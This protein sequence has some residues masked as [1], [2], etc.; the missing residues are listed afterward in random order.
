VFNLVEQDGSIG[1]IT[2]ET[3]SAT[4]ELSGR[5]STV[6]S[7]K[8]SSLGG[9]DQSEH[10]ILNKRVF[11]NQCSDIQKDQLNSAVGAAKGYV[12]KTVRYLKANPTGNPLQKTWYGIWDSSRYKKTLGGFETL[13]DA[14][15]RWTYDCSCTKGGGVAAYVY[16]TR[17]GYVYICPLFWTL[18]GVG[19][20]SRAQTIIHEGTHFIQVLNTEDHAYGQEA[21]KALAKKNPAN[22]VI[23]A[24]NNAFFALSTD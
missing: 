15:A 24:D 2:A 23:N 8:S 10:R 11:F 16:K 17:Y 6:K 22:A 20:N 19:Y 14:P 5:L 7:L 1:T 4:V 12:S 9:V 3:E 13:V 18:P 21:C